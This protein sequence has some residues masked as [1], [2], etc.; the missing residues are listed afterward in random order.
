MLRKKIVKYLFPFIG[1]SISLNL[2]FTYRNTGAIQHAFFS[3]LL[4]ILTLLGVLVGMKSFAFMAVPISEFLKTVFNRDDTVK[5][6]DIRAF[7]DGIAEFERSYSEND[8]KFFIIAE[9]AFDMIWEMDTGLRFRYASPS[10]IRHTG[11]NEQEILS[12][13]A[14]DLWRDTTDSGIIKFLNDEI[15]S[16]KKSPRSKRTVNRIF[17]VNH[18]GKERRFFKAEISVTVLYDKNSE[19]TSIIGVTR[20]IDSSNIMLR[21]LDNTKLELDRTSDRLKESEKLYRNIADNTRDVI[22]VMNRELEFTYCS[23]SV[24]YLQGYTPQQAISTPL[25]K[26]FTT[27]SLKAFNE[28][29]NEMYS[30]EGSPELAGRELV[31]VGEFEQIHKDGS[32]F[33]TEVSANIIFDKNGIIEKVYGVT[34]NI[35]ERKKYM[36]K[37]EKT[38]NELEHALKELS[39]VN[40]ELR[41][42]DQMKTNLLSNVSHELRTPLAIIKSYIEKMLFDNPKCHGGEYLKIIEKNIRHLDSLIESLL[43]YSRLDKGDNVIDLEVF[44]VHDLTVDII[45]AYDDELEGTG[46]RLDVRIQ[47]DLYVYADFRHIRQVLI[48]LLDNAVKFTS[49]GVVTLSAKMI[50]DRICF[51][52]K[53]TGI[54]I[55][56]DK[57]DFIFQRFYQ[58]DYSDTREFQGMGL[59][60]SIVKKILDLHKTEITVSSV[61]G[62]GT[63]MYFSL[64]SGDPE[65][66]DRGDD[67]NQNEVLD[68]ADFSG[69]TVLF[70]DDQED[71]LQ[72]FKDFFEEKGIQTM[73]C[74]SPLEVIGMDDISVFSIVFLDVSMS[75]LNGFDLCREL[76]RKD[77]GIPVVMLSAFS[78]RKH[79]DNAFEAGADDYIVKPFNINSI[80]KKITSLAR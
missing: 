42:L 52:V 80:L 10:F 19:I 4:L 34:R 49:K 45:S 48:N 27:Q 74:P 9:N 8:L 44:S 68:I 29:A 28:L 5:L 70:V 46:K 55:S 66:A 72:F 24:Y 41:G 35:D 76:K 75:E 43:V 73:I 7:H 16:Q 33:W 65:L 1:F 79:I 12:M 3:L 25:E 54:G 53:D 51:S 30:I 11:Y 71:M 36:E 56:G 78:E 62:E 47:K 50:K 18:S 14:T 20:N 13:Q 2:Y 22:W 69:K 23:P 57:I 60:L 26:K 39:K 61:E 63:E 58:I 40:A 21:E 59:G 17:Q 32:T 6:E 15:R 31:R 37:V 67:N 77:P 64:P 38:G